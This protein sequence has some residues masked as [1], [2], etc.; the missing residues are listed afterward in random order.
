MSTKQVSDAR[1]DGLQVGQSASDKVGLHG[2]TP[3]VQAAAIADVSVTGTYADDDTP[4]ETAINSILA[5]LRAKGI[6]ASA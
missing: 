6:I 5:A 1:T 2:V 3:V 4:I